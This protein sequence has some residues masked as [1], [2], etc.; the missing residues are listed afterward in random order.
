MRRLTP[1][2]SSRQLA[3][4]Q[5]LVGARKTWLSDAL[6]DALTRVDPVVLKKQLAAHV[7]PDAQQL[8]AGAGIRDEHVFPAP[9]VLEAAPSL[10]G[11]YRL[12]LGV[13]QKSFYQGATGFG[14]F[15]MMERYGTLSARQRVLLPQFCTAMGEALA[16]LVRQ[17]SPTI[18]PRDISELPLL[19]LGQQF[20]GAN[21]VLIGQQAIADVFHA[22]AEIVKPYILERDERQIVVAN[23]S[24]RRVVITLSSDPDVRIEEEFSGTLRRKVAV[25]IKGGTDR[26]NAHNR[27]GEAE[28]SHQKAKDQGFRDF[29]TLIAKKGLNVDIL[30][31]ESPTTNSWYDVAQVLG[32]RGDDWNEFRSRLA[33]EVGI[34]VG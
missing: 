23:A 18:T 29:W 16:D 34:P 7:P 31:R 17:V 8:L 30:R 9:A 33:G 10:V 21:N 14:P 22:I 5:L 1:P 3:F 28:K 11:Y 26:S 15:K 24:N 19:T 25:E 32:R 20:Q 6:S 2:S 27:A 13:P 12:L 4:H